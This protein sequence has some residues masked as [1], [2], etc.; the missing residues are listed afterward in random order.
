MTELTEKHIVPAHIA[1]VMDGNGRWA[2][3]RGLPRMAGHAAGV[4]AIRRTVSYCLQHNIKTLTVFAFSS[5]N[6]HRPQ[7]EVGSLMKLFLRS[8]KKEVK[9]LHNRQ[10]RMRFIGDLSRFSEAMQQEACNATMLTQNNAA[11]TFV[12]AF[13]YGGR[14]DIFQ[15]AKQL[16]KEAVE[17]KLDVNTL[18]EA[19][20]TKY[21]SMADLPEPDLF[22]RTSG[23]CRISNFLLWQIAYAELY[24]CNVFWPDFSEKELDEAIRVFATRNRRFGKV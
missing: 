9:E 6:W 4:L 10:V 15:A 23:E 8:L 18:E 5:E 3:S 14:W 19:R 12:L 11:L 21:L 16:T 20:F 17:Q 1:I 24:F 2:Q 22:I 7:K 13:N